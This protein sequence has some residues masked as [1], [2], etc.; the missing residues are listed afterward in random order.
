MT[1][2]S[3]NLIFVEKTISLTAI[4][5][6]II[7]KAQGVSRLNVHFSH[8]DEHIDDN[9]IKVEVNL[10][11]MSPEWLGFLLDKLLAKGANDVFYI[12]IY[13][14]KNRPGV[15]LQ[16]LC[17]SE[18]LDELKSIIFTETTTLGIRYSPIN[19]HRLERQFRKIETPWG[20]VTVKEGLHNGTIVQAA[21]EYDDC[22][23]LA[24]KANIPLK[25]VFQFVWKEIPNYS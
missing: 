1:S 12:P 16:L 11:D 8:R 7:L 21:P 5:D 15:L 10:D 19:V 3:S 23:R 6:Y 24:E 13:M 18:K 14:K 20:P 9:M 17:S 25:H 4:I 22:K 2:P